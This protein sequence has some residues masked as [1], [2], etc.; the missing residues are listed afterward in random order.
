MI[1]FIID[2][3]AHKKTT[4]KGLQKEM[5]MG[6]TLRNGLKRKVSCLRT[7]INLRFGLFLLLPFTLVLALLEA[8]NSC[9]W[10]LLGFLRF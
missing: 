2:I 8:R 6:F 3:F 4:S 9:K 10:F 1:I 5:I 7:D